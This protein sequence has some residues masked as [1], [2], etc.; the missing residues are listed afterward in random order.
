[1][2]VSFSVLKHDVKAFLFV[3]T[4]RDV[5]RREKNL[6][7]TILKIKIRKRAKLCLSIKDSAI[8]VIFSLASAPHA[9]SAIASFLQRLPARR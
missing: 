8:L 2:A 3:Q 7:A 9:V 1:L 6:R 4:N 5:A